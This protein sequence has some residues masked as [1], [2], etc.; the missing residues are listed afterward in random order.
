[1]STDF[2]IR[3][4]GVP[5]QL[6]GTIDPD[7]DVIGVVHGY[8]AKWMSPSVDMDGVTEFLRPNCFGDT[9]RTRD[10]V[11]LKNH[12]HDIAFGRVSE[13]Q[14]RLNCDS[15]GLAFELDLLDTSD[16]RDLKVYI[17]HGVQKYC[18]FGFPPDDCEEEYQ[19]QN[20]RVVRFLDKIGLVEVSIS[21]TFPAFTCSSTSMRQR[22]REYGEKHL[23]Q[24]NAQLEALKIYKG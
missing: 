21:V 12:N 7:N 3:S 16:G 17:T 18:S 10:I 5:V 23:A 2:I 11:C 8:I 19:T 1:M 4:S 15:V 9:W 13:G 22:A 20:G 24:R 6:D 14:L